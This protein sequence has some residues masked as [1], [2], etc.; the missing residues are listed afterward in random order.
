MRRDHSSNVRQ[1]GIKIEQGTAAP[2]SM[3]HA[4]EK[5]MQQGNE[6]FAQNEDQRALQQYQTALK[7]AQSLLRECI[8]NNQS[9]KAIDTAFAA[10]VVSHH[11]LA[12]V[13]A[14]KGDL[15]TAAL[16]LC[17]VHRCL[18]CICKDAS[19]AKPLREAAQRH[20]RRTY[21]EL[22]NFS[23]LYSQHPLVAKTLRHCGQF[24]ME[25]GRSLH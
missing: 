24:C 2:Q 10:Y 9:L 12:S 17:E 3:V 7:Q 20:G 15:N 8:Q 6:A 14:R 21:S 22:L 11:N 23:H 18:S 16:R 4:W 19:L 13:Y 25:Q 5:A 1:F